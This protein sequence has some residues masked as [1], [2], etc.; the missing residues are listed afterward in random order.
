MIRMR[1]SKHVHFRIGI[2]RGTNTKVELIVCWALMFLAYLKNIQWIQILR[3]TKS[4]IDSIAD[5]PHEINF[6]ENQN[7]E[8]EEFLPKN[9]LSIHL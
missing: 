9:Q 3:D 2:E 7:F 1:E 8:G 6:L 5:K 4:L